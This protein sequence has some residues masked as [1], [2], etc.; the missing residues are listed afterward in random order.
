M[1]YHYGLSQFKVS[2]KYPYSHICDFLTRVFW[3][4]SMQY[5]TVIFGVSRGLSLAIFIARSI[6]SHYFPAALGCLTQYVWAKGTSN[7][8]NLLDSPFYGRDS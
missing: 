4:V 2:L 3:R 5:Y 6:M 1:L 8:R 7:D